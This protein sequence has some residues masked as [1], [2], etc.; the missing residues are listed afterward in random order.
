MCSEDLEKLLLFPKFVA[1]IPVD[2]CHKL[3]FVLFEAVGEVRVKHIQNDGSAY[4]IYLAQK[5]SY[6]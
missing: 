2:L 3:S 1:L 6:Q 5:G 4:S